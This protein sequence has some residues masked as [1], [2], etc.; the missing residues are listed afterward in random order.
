MIHL[1]DCGEEWAQPVSQEEYDQA[2]LV[3]VAQARLRTA[4]VLDSPPSR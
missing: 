4:A 1:N 3:P 2:R